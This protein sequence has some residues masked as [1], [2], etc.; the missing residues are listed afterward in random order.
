MPYALEGL[1]AGLF[2]SKLANTARAASR[3]MHRS[4]S[5]RSYS[6][7]THQNSMEYSCELPFTHTG[8]PSPCHNLCGNPQYERFLFSCTEWMIM[9][10]IQKPSDVRFIV[11]LTIM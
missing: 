11:M 9:E 8:A 1:N 10:Q 4:W 2:C 7:P 5:R 3:R 6:H